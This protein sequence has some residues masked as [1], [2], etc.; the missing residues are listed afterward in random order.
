MKRLVSAIVSKGTHG[1]LEQSCSCCKIL[2]LSNI[3]RSSQVKS[4]PRPAKSRALAITP[5]SIFCI[6]FLHQI[7][8]IIRPFQWCLKATNCWVLIRRFKKIAHQPAVHPSLGVLL[9]RGKLPFD[10]DYGR[11]HPDV[12]ES[13]QPSPKQEEEDYIF[14]PHLSVSFYIRQTHRFI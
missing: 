14:I 3:S 8:K 2:L 7:S 12:N 4:M 1:S 9:H 10:Y 5:H 11:H 6:F 13:I